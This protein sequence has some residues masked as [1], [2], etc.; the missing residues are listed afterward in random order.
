MTAVTVKE[1]LEAGVHFGHQ[2]KRWNP[3]MRQFIFGHRNGIYIINLQKTVSR[4]VEA[5]DYIRRIAGCR[6]PCPTLLQEAYISVTPIVARINACFICL[7]IE[8]NS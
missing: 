8:P 1:L 5:L 4:F 6:I 7:S 2:T 3:K